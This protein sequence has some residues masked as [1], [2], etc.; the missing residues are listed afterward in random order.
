MKPSYLFLATGFEEIEALGTVDVL[1]RGG[2]EV[3]TIS[4][5][6]EKIVVGAHQIPVVA[7]LTIEEIEE[8][9]WLIL[10]GGLPGAT[11]LYECETLRELLTSHNAKGGK[12]GAIC[13]SPG[14]VLG[15]LGL[16]KGKTATCYPGFEKFCVGA[17]MKEA[18]SIVDG[19]IVTANGPSST[20][21]LGYEIL[22]IEKDRQTAEK[23]M[24]DMLL[25][26]KQQ[27]YFF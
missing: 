23:T 7:D 27:T 1:R 19:N 15:Q 17:N 4:V 16:L 12:I 13:A 22:K 18:R 11:N 21:N 3:K 9:N 20:L 8:A 14:V 26:P 25:F 10:P 24:Q 2:V 5:T 6:S